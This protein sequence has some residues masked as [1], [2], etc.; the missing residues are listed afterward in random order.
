VTPADRLFAEL[1]E[2]CEAMVVTGNQHWPRIYESLG[3]AM[4]EWGLE[5]TVQ[6]LES[7]APRLNDKFPELGGVGAGFAIGLQAAIRNSDAMV[8]PLT[9]ETQRAALRG[10]VEKEKK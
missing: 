5:R 3:K 4:A 2:F 6:E 8:L 10:V 7:M 1:C 9:Q